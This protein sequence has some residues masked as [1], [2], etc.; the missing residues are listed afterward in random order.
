[1]SL[2]YLCDTYEQQQRYAKPQHTF[3]PN[4]GLTRS[5]TPEYEKNYDNYSD[6]DSTMESLRSTRLLSASSSMSSV[7]CND[8]SAFEI[9]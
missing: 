3:S 7:D 5:N 1:M 8:P 9:E 6:R 2:Q 4:S